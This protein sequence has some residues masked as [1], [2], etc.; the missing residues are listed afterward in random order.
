MSLGDAAKRE[1]FLDTRLNRS[2]P[3][4]LSVGRPRA[5]TTSGNRCRTVLEL[6]L[7]TD[8]SSAVSNRLSSCSAPM[9]EQPS[10]AAS[11]AASADS[12]LSGHASNIGCRAAR[13]M[14]W[15]TGSC[16][17]AAIL[18]QVATSCWGSQSRTAGWRAA[19]CRAC[20][21]G[22]LSACASRG[23]CLTSFSTGS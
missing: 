19:I 20:C 14:T 7:S 21:R 17:A 10:A 22:I 11:F 18:L 4:V 13:N 23:S 2:K 6:M 12:L 9:L 8:C 3:L 1:G 5:S 16:T 15:S